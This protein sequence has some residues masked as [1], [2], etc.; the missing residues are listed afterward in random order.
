[1]DYKTRIEKLTKLLNQ[2]A[3]EYYVL[4]N[5]S[6]SDYEYDQ[7]YKELVELEQAYP[8]FAL[9]DSPTKRVGDKVLDKFE[10]ITHKFKMMSINDVFDI[11]ELRK[12]DSDI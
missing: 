7:L 12:F 9:I 2:Y 8:E 11:D 3:Y 10:K 6:I 1:M 5:P 4:D